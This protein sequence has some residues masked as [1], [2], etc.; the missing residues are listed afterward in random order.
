MR[1]VYERVMVVTELPSGAGWHY[2]GF[3]YGLEP[4]TLPYPGT[5]YQ[6]DAPLLAAEFAETSRRIQTINEYGLPTGE[7]QPCLEQDNLFWFRWITGHQVSFIL[8][9]MAANLLEEVALQRRSASSALPALIHYVDGY[10]AMLLYTGS[11]PRAEYH[12]VIR[13]SMQLRHP[14][15][16]GGWAPDYLPVRQLLRGRLAPLDQSPLSAELMEAVK[17]NQLVHEHVAAKLVPDGISLLR[18]SGHAARRQDG[19]LLSLLYDNYFMT[20]RGPVSQSDVIAQL[21][22][23]LVAIMQDVEVNGLAPAGERSPTESADG[24]S[25]D[26]EIAD[27]V[28]ACERKITEILA[29]VAPRAATSLAESA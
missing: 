5:G 29:E 21:F 8:W 10:S 27:G 2:G 20:W 14:G 28:S 1:E 12:R 22:R 19:R 17:L 16:S 24:M 13:P 15:F 23:R 7:V 3:P 25:A 6:P 11:C 26:A 4:L 9:R 18:Q